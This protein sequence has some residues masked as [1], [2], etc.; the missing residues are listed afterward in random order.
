V[1][2]DTP[3]VQL[4]PD[5]VAHVAQLA[6]LALSPEELELY[7]QQLSSVLE[8]VATVRRLEIAD[9]PPT[10]HA[11][12]VADV[13]RADELEPSLDPEVVLAAAPA[14]EGGRFRVPRILG[15]AP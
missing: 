1:T 11:L 10:S 7:A 2:N 14:V 6:R 3:A 9:V 13:L 15:E 4:T 5:E 8:H 12:P